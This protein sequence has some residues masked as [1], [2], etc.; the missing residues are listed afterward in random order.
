M[1]IKDNHF[2]EGVGECGAM[3]IV[4]P[5]AVGAMLYQIPGA[6]VGT[7]VEGTKN[8]LEKLSQRNESSD[9]GRD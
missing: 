1:E 2:C 3:L 6:I 4:A 8:G 5:L 7:A 9:G